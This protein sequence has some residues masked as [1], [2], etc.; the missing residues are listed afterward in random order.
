[1]D[2]FSILCASITAGATL[3]LAYLAWKAWKEGRRERELERLE[4][5]KRREATLSPVADIRVTNLPPYIEINQFTELNVTNIGNCNMLK[6][7]TRIYYSW[8]GPTSLILNWQ[9]DVIL[10]PNENKTFLFRLP[11]PPIDRGE[12]E[13]IVDCRCIHPISK[14]IVG[15]ERRFKISISQHL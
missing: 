7:A 9:D 12:Q 13:I 8:G 2:W 11:D 14:I 6:P 1:M 5:Q 10:A 15:W 3:I 4:E